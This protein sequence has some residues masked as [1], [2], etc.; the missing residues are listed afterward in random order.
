[1]PLLIPL[2]LTLPG[3]TSDYQNCNSKSV[4]RRHRATYE[5]PNHQ[6]QK[7][8]TCRTVPC[9]NRRPKT[10]RHLRKRE[11]MHIVPAVIRP[12]LV[13]QG[14]LIR[15]DVDVRRLPAAD[16]QEAHGLRVA[17]QRHRGAL[18][19]GDLREGAAAPV[20][21]EDLRV[22]ARVVISPYGP[23]RV[24]PGTLSVPV[25]LVTTMPS[26]RVLLSARAMEGVTENTHIPRD[27]EERFGEVREL[28]Q[29][30]EV[31]EAVVHEGGSVMAWADDVVR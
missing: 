9:H 2:Q 31:G 17:R 8:R 10:R 24:A 26:W 13:V 21:R 28:V 4:W 30:R 27:V 16:A 7:T 11:G 12:D 20:V 29:G 25:W 18:G 5:S 1:M 19:A 22:G 3:V 6:K 23:E 14:A 15:E